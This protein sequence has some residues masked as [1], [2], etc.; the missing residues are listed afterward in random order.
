MPYIIEQDGN[1]KYFLNEG[2]ASKKRT[3][4]LGVV[5]VPPKTT[6]LPA[7][8]QPLL[9]LSPRSQ[10]RPA[11]P[12]QFACWFLKA[13]VLSPYFDEGEAAQGRT[14]CSCSSSGVLMPNLFTPHCT[15]QLPGTLVR[16]ESAPRVS[17]VPSRG[18][19]APLMGSP[20]IIHVATF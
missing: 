17:P 7:V 19:R 2:I 10:R 9:R 16:W 12:Q 8:R 13:C 1:S 6:L 18:E 11:C 20:Q 4:G 3:G 14:P 15:Q 5:H